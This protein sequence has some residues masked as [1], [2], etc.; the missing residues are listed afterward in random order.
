MAFLPREKLLL[1]LANRHLEHM[2]A[3]TCTL[4]SNN[5]GYES[6]KLKMTEILNFH[7]ESVE[8]SGCSNPRTACEPADPIA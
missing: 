2:D 4:Q 5:Y 1:M 7:L 6:Y 3:P 8:Q